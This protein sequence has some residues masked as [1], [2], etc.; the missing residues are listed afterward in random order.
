MKS[1]CELF[2]IIN[3]RSKPIEIES[4]GP[5]SYYYEESYTNKPKKINYFG[6]LG[7][8]LS[9]ISAPSIAIRY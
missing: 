1:N 6:G 3:I 2:H 8:F 9:K 4:N 5:P 7:L